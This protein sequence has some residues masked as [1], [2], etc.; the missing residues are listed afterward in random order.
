M[1][2]ANGTGR[3]VAAVGYVRRSTEKQ[4]ASIPE[5]VKAV[6]AFAADRGYHIVR[7]YT[8]DGISG[9]GTVKRWRPP[10]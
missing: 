2:K 10:E 1:S 9:D 7:W 6:E 5:Q 4:E 8:D 3:L